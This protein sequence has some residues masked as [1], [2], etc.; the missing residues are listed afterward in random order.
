MDQL[1]SEV[2]KRTGITDQQA[3]DAVQSVVGFIKEKL[4]PGMASQ[5]DAL[6]AGQAPDLS[7]VNLNDA[8]N[9]AKDLGGMFGK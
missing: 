7:N 1:I 4:P 2:T 3:R 9:I 6:M 8:G 5:I